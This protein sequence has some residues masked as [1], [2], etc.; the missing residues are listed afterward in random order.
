LSLLR[1]TF[2]ENQNSSMKAYHFS[3]THMTLDM[4]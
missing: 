2:Y 1:L 4:S 3:A